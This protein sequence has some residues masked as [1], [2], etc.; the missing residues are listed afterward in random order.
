MQ[1]D[2]KSPQPVHPIRRIRNPVLLILFPR[3]C[4]QCR[5]HGSF[6]LLPA[7][8]PISDRRP[9]CLDT[10]CRRGLRDQQQIAAALPNQ[11]LEPIVQLSGASPRFRRHLRHARRISLGCH[12]P[13]LGCRNV[14]LE[15]GSGCIPTLRG[16]TQNPSAVFHRAP[17]IIQERPSTAPLRLG[18]TFASSARLSSV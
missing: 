5:Q 12:N 7:E 6:D 13:Y 11:S 17:V 2:A 9:D 4:G 18:E 10:N 16:V 8:S 15:C 1:I 3:M 14:G